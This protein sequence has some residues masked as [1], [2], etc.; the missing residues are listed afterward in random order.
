MREHISL[1]EACPWAS[2]PDDIH[3]DLQVEM[4]LMEQLGNVLEDGK[5][6]FWDLIEECPT[7]FNEILTSRSHFLIHV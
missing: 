2:W 6:I 5:R 3:L 7:W 1:H 4:Y